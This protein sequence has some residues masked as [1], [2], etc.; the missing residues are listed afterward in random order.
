MSPPFSSL[1]ISTPTLAVSAAFALIFSA[2]CGLAQQLDLPDFGSSADLVLSSSQERRLGKEF[3]K[4]VRE[5]LPVIED[6]LLTDYLE[7]LG[8]RL[9]AAS[10]TGSGKYSFFLIDDPM[11]NA[12]AG[13]DGHIGVFS[14][15]V[16]ASGSESELAAVL[17]HEIAHVTQHHLTRMLEDQKRLSIPATAALIAAAILGA[18]VNADLGIAA[19]AG[20][21]AAAAQRQINFSRENEKEADRFGIATLAAAGFDPY[22]MPG[23]FERLA[24]ATRAY[25]SDA[26][27]FLRTHPVTANRTADALG[28]AAN[29]GHRQRP[30]DLRFHLARARLRELSFSNPQKAVAHFRSQL[31]GKRYRNE[32]AARYGY[33]L[34]LTRTGQIAAA[35]TLAG[36]LLAKHPNQLELVILQARLD[37]KKGANDQAVTTLR[38]AVGLRPSNIPLR[39]AYA[40]ILMESGHPERALKTL[41]DVSRR[42]PG[43]TLIYQKMSDA[44]LK[45]GQKAATYRYR[46]EKLYAEGDLEPAIRQLEIALRQPGLSYY[47]ASG[48]QVRLDAFKQERKDTEKKR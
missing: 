40:D 19:M 6:P 20:V 3:M 45:S 9:V 36:E 24:K 28:R 47:D 7:S 1:S 25:E 35:R 14:G 38:T 44:A 21:Q 11:I 22:A 15:L 27:E 31:R 23:F 17:A 30:D 41:E 18:Q 37:S 32:I 12:F 13:P 29:Y 34:A 2:T 8:N 16:L 26:P 5:S 33:A 48:L 42:R 4:S 39:I 10:G 46:A 43:D